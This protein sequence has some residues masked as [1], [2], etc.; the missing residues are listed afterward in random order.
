[1]R[2]KF[3]GRALSAVHSALCLLGA[4]LFAL[5]IPPH[6]Q[7]PKKIPRIGILYPGSGDP[8]RMARRGTDA[9]RQDLHELGWVDGENIVLEY[10]WANENEDR[11]SMLA[12][13]LLSMNIDII[14][15]TSAQ[16][17]RAAQRLTKT[18]P[19]VAIVMADPVGMGLVKSLGQPAGNLTGL[20]IMGPELAGKRLELLKEL[21]PRISRVAVLANVGNVDR[22]TSIKEIESVARS[23][24]VQLQILN[25]KKP[26]EIENAFA[27]MV[28][29]KAAALTVLTQNI[30]F[31]NRTRIV[32]LAAKSRMPTMY[33]RGGYV[34]AGGLI[35][36][37]PDRRAYHRR[38]AY[39]VDRILR[40]AKPAE[41][42]VEQPTRFELVI[43][44]KAARALELKIP[45]HILMEADRVIE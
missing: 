34:E 36:Y 26:D 6:A 21:T 45:A 2:K 40:G 38:A 15:A 8:L 39:F 25:V 44:L 4:M 42:P 37:G 9:F 1:M 3:T 28:R 33:P 32:E 23:S 16:G 11:L 10:R 20:S 41:L 13:E 18:T 43:N 19:I 7:Q 27:A 5:S 14:V 17:A 24:S 31:R 35:S 22:E 30:F 29:E 12:A